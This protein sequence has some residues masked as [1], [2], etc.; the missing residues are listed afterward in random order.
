MEMQDNNTPADK[1]WHGKRYAFFNH[2]ECEAFPCHT[3]GD[4]DNFNCLFCYCPLYM[5]GRECAGSPAYS[6]DGVKDCTNCTLPH[7][8]ENYGIIVGRF[9]DIVNKM[10]KL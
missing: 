4:P 9:Q 6:Q 10:R 1:L 8:R 2:S 7:E 5:L 3:T